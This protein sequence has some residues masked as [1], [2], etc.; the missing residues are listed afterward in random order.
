MISSRLSKVLTIGIV[1]TLGLV[2][3]A[4]SA[5]AIPAFA[6]NENMKCSSCH[7]AWPMLNAFG[8]MYKENGYQV[9]RGKPSQHNKISDLLTLPNQFPLALIVN[10]R[11]YDKS[12]N[13]TAK[14]RALHELELIA[15]GNFA[16]YA[17][18]FVEGELED[19]TD[20]TFKVPHAVASLHLNQYI[21]VTLGKSGPFFANPYNNL[22][23]RRITRAK[24]AL[25][26]VAG[27]SGANIG[28][29]IQNVEV[30]GRVGNV[31]YMAGIGAD[32][33]DSEGE[34]SDNFAGSLAVDV[35]PK[36]LS[37]GAFAYNGKEAVTT[38]LNP[39]S[40]PGQPIL[41]PDP[42]LLIET[43]F[44]FTRY[45]VTLQ[46]QLG[47]LNYQAAVM[48]SEDDLRNS[49]TGLVMGDETN[50][51]YQGEV[52]YTLECDSLKDAPIPVSQL[53]PFVR[54]QNSDRFGAS[55]A[56]TDA[57]F[58]LTAYHSENFKT[59]L[60]WAQNVTGPNNHRLT[61]FLVFGL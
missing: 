34:G 4:S 52:F 37:I 13:K 46:G 17:S 1:C 36:A 33:G 42:A 10:L 6:R 24:T 30:S 56:Q 22:N 7:T 15:A 35:L 12:K 3:T 45:G 60:E 8:R 19:E 40:L 55:G 61:L 11:P 5:S 43:D 38:D 18:F 53:V 47:D 41:Q 21:N 49:S 26:S 44:D 32:T 16:G 54:V 20:F 51:V 27:A 29:A 31:F 50:Y 25:V 23:G 57:I 9:T 28:S 14:I 39:T 59:S 58:N 48:K 2:F